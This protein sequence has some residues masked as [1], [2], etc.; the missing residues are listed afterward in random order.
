MNDREDAIIASIS[1]NIDLVQC[2]KLVFDMVEHFIEH[3]VCDT[4]SIEYIM[5]YYEDLGPRLRKYNARAVK[6]LRNR[7]SEGKVLGFVFIFDTEEHF[8][9]DYPFA[10]GQ[11]KCML[12]VDREESIIGIPEEGEI[13]LS[14]KEG[15]L[16]LFTQ[17][18]LVDWFIQVANE[19]EAVYGY[20]DFLEAEIPTPVS[21][22]TMLE[23]LTGKVNL[24][25]ERYDEV[26]RGYFWGGLLGPK[27]IEKLGGLDRV[28]KLLPHYKLEDVKM[29]NGEG[30][31]YQLTSNVFEFEPSKWMELK[32]FL[33]PLLPE[34]DLQEIEE[35]DPYGV[36]RKGARLV[37]E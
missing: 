15:L 37:F 8:R 25:R 27:H 32:Q 1:T 18:K 13:S 3:F 17:D 22:S 31:Y 35:N 16:N 20:I 6:E 10:D 5:V 26:V 9:E 11:F 7:F 29:A 21:L 24:N 4:H 30:V 2:T 33:K 23:R 12:K 34:E 28:R 19:V 36:T 14:L